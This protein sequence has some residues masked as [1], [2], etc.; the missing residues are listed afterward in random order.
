MIHHNAAYYDRGLAQG[1]N[2]AKVGTAAASHV[3][4]G[5]TFTNANGVGLSGTMKNRGALNWNPSSSTSYSVPAGYY[6]G[7]TLSSAGAY[8]AGM[9]AADNRANSNSVNY[10]TG[11][12]AGLAAGKATYGE[13]II[14]KIYLY[15]HTYAYT[16]EGKT[17]FFGANGTSNS[18]F[19]IYCGSYNT[20]SIGTTTA[21]VNI[22]CEKSDG[23]TNTIVYGTTMNISDYEYITIAPSCSSKTG[24]SYWNSTSSSGAIT[25]TNISLK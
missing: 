17:E 3:L 20:F 21:S 25:L 24:E 19:K 14:P 4:E 7:G 16:G 18:E 13:I 11:Y 6:S 22:I 12:N 10:Q 15:N 5:K 23:T 8:N 2:S 1:T 9:T